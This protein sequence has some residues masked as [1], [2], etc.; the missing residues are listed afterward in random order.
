MISILKKQNKKYQ[1]AVEILGLILCHE[2]C[3]NYVCSW[4]GVGYV[5][6]KSQFNLVFLNCGS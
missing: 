3:F 4:G 5:S 2:I 6:L 1:R